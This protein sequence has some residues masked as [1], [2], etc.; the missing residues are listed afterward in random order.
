MS[1]PLGTPRPGDL[2]TVTERISTGL[3]GGAGIAPGT[4][5]VVISCENGFF[6][7]RVNLRADNGI[8]TVD[9]TAKLN[10]VR[11]SRRG[12]GLE[13]F[14]RRTGRLT[15]MRLGVAAALIGPLVIYC[16]RFL[17]FE[18]GTVPQLISN[19]TIGAVT[20]T[21]ELAAYALEQPVRAL[22]FVGCGWLLWRFAFGR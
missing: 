19:L 9:V 14:E 17:V 15:A 6:A 13:R 5:A 8:G 10:Q 11:L 3:F 12:Y 21:V 22:L 4:S 2:V 18:H 7:Q 20:Q 16:I 1:W